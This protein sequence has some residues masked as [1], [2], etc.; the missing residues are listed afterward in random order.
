[1][2]NAKATQTHLSSNW[3]P[4]ENKGKATAA[5][6]TCY[7]FIIGSLLYLMMGTRPDISYAVTHLS[8]FTM[9]PSEDHHKAAL[10]ICHYLTGTQD[11]KLVYGKTADKGL[12]AYTDSDWAADKIW[13]QSVTGYFFKL[14]DSIISWCSH[15][16]KTVALSSTEA[17]YMALSNCSH[18]AVWIKT[19]IE[20]LGIVFKTVPIYCDNQGASFIASNPVQESHTKHIDIRYHYIC[21]LVGAKKVETMFVP[22][23]MNPAHMFTKNLQKVKF[24]KFRSQL[25]LDFEDSPDP[26]AN[27][28]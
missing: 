25:G 26:P 6:I 12:M 18:Q 16:Q 7:Q 19:M 11:Y 22:G 8:Q 24:L 10:H 4:K 20:E 14:A 1:M 9:N 21:E 28:L 3:D 13:C 27:S 15:A 5:E 2:T 17:E 23:E